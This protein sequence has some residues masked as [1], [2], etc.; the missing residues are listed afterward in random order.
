MAL[1]DRADPASDTPQHDAQQVPHAPDASL[2]HARLEL[3]ALLDRFTEGC[4]GTVETAVPGF[5]VHRIMNPGGPKPG[6]QTPVLGLIA[7]GSKRVMVGDEVYV[8][9]PMHYLV[10][11]V[12]LPVMGQ[13][14]VASATE[15]YLGLRLDLDVE[16]IT[17][18]IRDEKLPPAAHSDASRGLYVNRLGAPML[19]A[20]LRLLRLLDTPEDIPI[21]APL[22]KREILYRLLMNGQGARLRQIALTDSQTQRIAKAIL[23]LRQNFDQPLRV[24]AIAR[25]VHMSVSSLHHHFK[26]VTAMSPLQYQ[27]QLRLQEARRL[28]LLDMAD[29]ATAAHRVGYESASQFSREYS[30]LFGAPPLR[31]TRR[32]R[33]AAGA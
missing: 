8:Y 13:V 14:T 9:D 12:D 18:L 2:D 15:P 20:V 24:E 7:Q 28:M 6:I 21:L 10:S 33:D 19:D 22:V 4:E 23:L 32:W 31:D 11:S 26:A 16:E 29:A 17:E 3:V 5:F 1:N 25:D 30:R 27:K